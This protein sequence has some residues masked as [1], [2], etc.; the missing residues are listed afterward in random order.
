M[1]V[2]FFQS[3]RLRLIRKSFPSLKPILRLR[4]KTVNKIQ[5]P[6]WKEAGVARGKLLLPSVRNMVV[7]LG[8]V[9]ERLGAAGLHR[10]R[11]QRYTLLVG[12]ASTH[13]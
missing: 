6:P 11:R 12:D 9:R 10:W 5:S 4:T 7:S 13:L 3:F 1:Y 2:P 8:H